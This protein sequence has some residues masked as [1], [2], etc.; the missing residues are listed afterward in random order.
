MPNQAIKT[1]NFGKTKAN[2]ITVG[3][4]LYDA[5]GVIA[6]PRSESD[7]Y[8]VGNGT[9]IYT[10]GNSFTNVGHNAMGHGFSLIKWNDHSLA[11]TIFG[12]RFISA[13]FQK[14]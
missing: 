11:Y 4:T 13:N 14:R 8:E 10:I 3:Y 7:V 12:V 5:D 1:V 2:L 9:G 6:S